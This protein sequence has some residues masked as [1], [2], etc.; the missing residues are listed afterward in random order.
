MKRVKRFQEG[1]YSGDYDKSDLDKSTY[2]TKAK[3]FKDA[4]REARSAGDKTFSWRGKSYS[5]E[6]SAP[7]AKAE[8][9]RESKRE[10]STPSKRSTMDSTVPSAGPSADV[11]L[12]TMDRVRAGLRNALPG[13][14]PLDSLAAL[15]PGLGRAARAAGSGAGEMAG[16]AR[17]GLAAGREE[18][19]AA[20]L[21]ARQAEARAAGLES[22]GA[23]FLGRK[24]PG[25][26]SA[27]G[28]SASQYSGP[29]R[30]AE[31][32]ADIERMAGEFMKKGGKVK[33]MASGG[34]VTASKRAD[35]IAKR[36]KTRG[37]MR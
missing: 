29:G 26:S 27:Q 4:F 8:P 3:S 14:S 35:G 1:G 23:Q 10:E 31:D 34:K 33:K 15:A 7:A 36:G 20:R 30:S 21:A 22:E 9:K 28:R 19:A 5:T 25:I 24:S 16:A 13:S 32:I 18:A 37:M 6:L 12:S 17:R 11:E 2:T